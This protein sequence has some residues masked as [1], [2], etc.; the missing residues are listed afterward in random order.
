MGERIVKVKAHTRNIGGKRIAVKAFERRT[1]A[2]MQSSPGYL[3][4]LMRI[5]RTPLESGA[6]TLGWHVIREGDAWC[7]VGPLFEDLLVSPSG[8]GS[9][10]EQARAALTLRHQREDTAVVPQLAAFRLWDDQTRS[11]AHSA[12]RPALNRRAFAPSGNLS[13]DQL[14]LK[15]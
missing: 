5:L 14:A 15:M 12:I 1:A 4:R 8:W 7:A 10:P 3:A 6:V 9:T 13:F 11:R 2:C